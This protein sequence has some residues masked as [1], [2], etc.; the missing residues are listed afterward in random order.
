MKIKIGKYP[1]WFGPYQL[2]EKI[3]FWVPE[4]EDKYGFKHT[5]RKVHK[6]GEW[7]AHGSIEPEQKVGEISNWNRD[8]PKTLLYKLLEWI[9]ARKKR[10]IK[11][12]I[13][14][15]DTWNMEST[16]ALIILPMLKQLKET[17][18]GS[19]IIDIE[20]LPEHLRT[21]NHN[22][23]ETQ[24]CFDFYH[25]HEHESPT[26][27]HWDWV[28]G[29]MIHAFEHYVDQSWED[30]YHAG[31]HDML[32]EKLKDGNYLMVKGPNDTY[33]CDYDGLDKE[34]KRI[35]NGFRLFGKYYRGLWD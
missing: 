1:E 25:E 24:E 3:L 12:H 21:T 30:K 6:F 22:S 23:W 35:E 10:T 31:E 19:Q 29:E 34:W 17:K 27:D 4:E 7:L 20:D 2:A 15:W 13:D 9:H 5:A 26:H 32:W 28:L 14:K 16:L 11:I 8:R 33:S 18:H